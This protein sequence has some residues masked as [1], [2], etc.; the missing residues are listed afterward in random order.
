LEV[1][2]LGKQEE[3]YA[4]AAIQRLTLFSFKCGQGHEER[5][6]LLEGIASR[7]KPIFE[8]IRGVGNNTVTIK[9]WCINKKVVASKNIRTP[10]CEAVLSEMVDKIPF[11]TSRFPDRPG[12]MEERQKG[13]Q[14]LRWRLKI[15]GRFLCKWKNECSPF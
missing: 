12:R 1:D 6:G 3:L 8:G 14:R 7:K 2:T 5:K 10:T 11:S 9:R 13:V 15:V 4:E